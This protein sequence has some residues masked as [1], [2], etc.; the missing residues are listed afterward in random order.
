MLR[1]QTY[2]TLSI[3]LSDLNPKTRMYKTYGE[4]EAEYE[5]IEGL[6]KGSRVLRAD[7]G[8]VYIFIKDK[9]ARMY[10]SCRHY[11][12][13]YKCKGKGMLL[14]AENKFYHNGSHMH[15][16]H[17]TLEALQDESLAEKT[18]LSSLEDDKRNEPS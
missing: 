13:P 8:F 18:E 14:K 4:F 5:I 12:F 15:N 6:R 17:K 7:D 3:L 2:R 10:L 1:K 9:E 16:C 11:K